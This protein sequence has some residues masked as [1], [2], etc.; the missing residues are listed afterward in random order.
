MS[1]LGSILDGGGG[2]I[3]A[4]SLN[5]YRAALSESNSAAQNKAVLEA[6]IA[7]AYAAG[8]GT[9]LMPS[10]EF[11]INGDI[12]LKGG[13]SIRGVL[14]E[15]DFLYNCQD[16]GQEVLKGTYLVGNGTDILFIG[17]TTPSPGVDSTDGLGIVDIG[18]FAATNFATL[19]KT[20]A[21]N[22]NGLAF[23][24]IENIYMTLMTDWIFDMTNNQHVVIKRVHS[25]DS[26][27]GIKLAANNSY[28]APGL[29]TVKETYIFL[30]Q[31]GSL[32]AE[33]PQ[34][35]AFYLVNSGT[36][37]GPDFQLDGIKLRDIQIQMYSNIVTTDACAV[38]IEGASASFAV[39]NFDAKDVNFDGNMNYC[40]KANY[41]NNMN[42]EIK[43][44][45]AVLLNESVRL[46][47]SNNARITSLN[48]GVKI[49]IDSASLYCFLEGVINSYATGSRFARGTHHIVSFNRTIYGNPVGTRAGL[50][51]D[52]TVGFGAIGVSRMN[53][54]TG[55]LDQTTWPAMITKGTR[56]ESGTSI[57]IGLDRS[58]I[59]HY[60][61]AGAATWTLPTNPPN[62]FEMAIVNRAGTGVITV[63]RGGT[64]TIGDFTATTYAVPATKGASVYLV[65]DTDSG[66]W[67]ILGKN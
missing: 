50:V 30:H 52:P 57:T 20:G 6:A 1:I 40:V 41:S 48:T 7:A 61:G 25:Y 49:Y 10:G 64:N 46:E 3:S 33:P 22:R 11:N 58:G 45:P 14:P 38:R 16:L 23:S 35:Y 17:K 28:C 36:D 32:E 42:I 53:M 51:F 43:H 18:Y 24:N 19:I 21:L 66:N 4:A 39:N 27:R 26:P 8:G 60:T 34:R 29:T 2:G 37:I 12:E 55:A 9:V 44:H 63:T 56:A 31:I 62:G 65:F 15:L 5:T 54:V 59:Y 13:V 47:N 67:D